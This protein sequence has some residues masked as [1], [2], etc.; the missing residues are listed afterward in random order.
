M[1]QENFGFSFPENGSRPGMTQCL[2][3]LC[4]LEEGRRVEEEKG[5][6]AEGE[7]AVVLR[8]GL[9][10]FD[11]GGTGFHGRGDRYWWKM[12]EVEEVK[13]ESPPEISRRFWIPSPAQI[14]IGPELFS[15]SVCNKTFNR[16]TSG[17]S[18]W[19]RSPSDAGNAGSPS[20][21]EETGGLTRRTAAGAGSAPADPI[22]STRDP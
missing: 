16:P 18:T 4:K 11:G 21:S 6:R 2:P 14:L 17:G 8:I 3:L 13:G 15:C 10:A 9:A 19:G 7:E 1:E 22:S 12:K 20:P 5:E